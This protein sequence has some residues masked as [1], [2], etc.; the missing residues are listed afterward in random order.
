MKSLKPIKKGNEIFNDYGPLPGSDLL[1]RYGYVTEN[2]KQ[3]DVVE[4]S[5]GLITEVATKECGLSG[6][7]ITKRVGYL[8]EIGAMDDDAFDISHWDSPVKR[9]ER[10]DE[11]SNAQIREELNNVFPEALMMLV[12]L[13]VLPFAEFS[14]LQS[15]SKGPKILPKRGEKNDFPADWFRLLTMV[16]TKRQHEYGTLAF[17][18]QRTLRDMLVD[19]DKTNVG[20]RRRLAALQ[21][22]IGEKEVLTGALS[23]LQVFENGGVRN[24]GAEM[25]KRPADED[26]DV[27]MGDISSP[28]KKR[29]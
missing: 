17:D 27:E 14:S 22:R 1:R 24:G 11:R 3:Y 6:D 23:I 10:D 13:L 26:S 21:V 29:R 15:S 4:I 8:E 28:T 12:L 9:G 2:Y 5:L 16:L 25:K 20:S 7:D 19:L 18:D